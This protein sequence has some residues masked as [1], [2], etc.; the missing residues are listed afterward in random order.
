MFKF[1]DSC[2]LY[3]LS[4][5]CDVTFIRIR[6]RN[7]LI[8]LRRGNLFVWWCKH[9]H[10][11]LTMEV[12]SAAVRLINRSEDKSKELKLISELWIRAEPDVTL[13]VYSSWRS[14]SASSRADWTHIIMS[15]V[16][17]GFQ[18]VSYIMFLWFI[19][20]V[21]P[22]KWHLYM[23]TYDFTIFSCVHCMIH[24]SIEL[25]IIWFLDDRSTLPSYTPFYHHF[26]AA[27]LNAARGAFQH[28]NSVLIPENNGGLE[29]LCSAELLTKRPRAVWR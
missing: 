23:L 26:N 24:G 9:Q 29:G 4:T 22:W 14:G 13:G 28:C 3:F 25:F 12:I 17:Y 21:K 27:S 2:S 11:H 10:K 1:R 6:I 18:T 16:M 7:P 15:C 8:S 20:T 5:L 19:A